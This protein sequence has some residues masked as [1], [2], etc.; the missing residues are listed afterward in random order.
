VVPRHGAHV[1]H[2]AARRP[3]GFRTR[4]HREHIEGDYKTPPPPGKYADRYKRNKESLKQE[5][6]KLDPEMRGVVGAA[7][8]GWLVWV[9]R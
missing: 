4:H 7:L 2:L 8:R 6:V 1:R 3:R 9:R 5:P